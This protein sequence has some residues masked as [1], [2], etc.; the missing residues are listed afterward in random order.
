MLYLF[1][2]KY[3]PAI[4]IWSIG[5]IFAEVLIGKPLF[6]GKNVVHQLDLITDLLGTPPLDAISK[7]R[8]D[9][10]RKYLTCMRK[11]QPASF[12]QK[13][14]KADPMALKLLRRL[15]AFD[16]KD[17]PSAEEALL[18]TNLGNSLPNWRK[19]AAE[20]DYWHQYRGNM[21]LCQGNFFYALS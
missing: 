12:S 19:M 9:K 7:V 13:F 17:R 2:F 1:L 18:L 15:L 11:K 10:A 14:P 5:C 16:P 3:T 6:P 8:N 21:L 4:D 20:L